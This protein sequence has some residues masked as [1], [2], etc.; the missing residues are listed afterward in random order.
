MKARFTVHSFRQA[1]KRLNLDPQEVKKL[2]DNGLVVL[3][4]KD[5]STNKAHKLFFSMVDANWFVAVQDE[6][7]GELVTVLP[8][9]Y[10]NRWRISS[11]ALQLARRIALGEVKPTAPVF[12]SR[13][14]AFWFSAYLQGSKGTIRAVGL[15]MLP[16]GTYHDLEDLRKDRNLY[17]Q[18]VSLLVGKINDGEVV[19]SVWVRI[20]R[21][22]KAVEIQPPQA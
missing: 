17:S 8:H 22:G 21:K 11:E 1:S 12:T 9:N 19:Q 15:G 3:I 10:H 18:L 5:E 2:I 13:G 14:S 20:G 16:E 4:G 6:S 7:T